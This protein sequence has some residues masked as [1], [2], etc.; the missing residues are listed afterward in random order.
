MICRLSTDRSALELR[1]ETKL[2]ES[3]G[4]AP[5]SG[6]TG[7]RFRDECR[8]LISTWTPLSPS[9]GFAPRPLAL[10]GR[11]TTVIPRWNL[12]GLPGRT[13]TCN[14]RVRSS[15]FCVFELR[16]VWELVGHLGTAPSV[17][18]SQAGWIAIFLVPDKWRPGRVLPPLSPARQAGES[19]VPLPSRRTGG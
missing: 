10:T 1:K 9:R 15:A 17:S 2:A 3:A 13:S 11:W 14:L 12:S 4:N 19:A 18:R 8:Q 5:A 6:L 16:G 7:S